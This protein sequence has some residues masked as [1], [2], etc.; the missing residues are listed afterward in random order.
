MS[1]GAARA[2]VFGALRH[3][4]APGDPRWRRGRDSNPRN[5]FGIHRISNPV[6]NESNPLPCSELQPESLEGG[7]QVDDTGATSREQEQL[8]DAGRAALRQLLEL[9]ERER[10]W[11]IAT[12]I[13]PD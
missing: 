2:V 8:S 13:R 7:P 9:P 6:G 12:A 11:V 3:E 4:R 1:A 5:P 10:M